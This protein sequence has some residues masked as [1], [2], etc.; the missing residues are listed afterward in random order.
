MNL[1][2]QLVAV[3]L[4]LATAFSSVAQENEAPAEKGKFFD[5]NKVY[6]GAN[7]GLSLLHGDLRQ[8]N[9]APV[10]NYHSE[11]GFGGNFQAGMDLNHAVSASLQF[12]FGSLNGTRRLEKTQNS[13][14]SDA[15]YT[16]T[17]LNVQFD[18]TKLLITKPNPKFTYYTSVGVG[19]MSFRS[20]AYRLESGFLESSYG[21]LGNEANPNE[22]GEK[23]SR[24]TE[25]VIPFA[26]G[27]KYKLSPQLFLNYELRLIYTNTDKLDAVV[28]QDNDNASLTSLGITYKF[29]M[30]KE[31]VEWVDPLADVIDKVE[32][33]ESKVE[34][35]TK[36]TDGDG[37]ADMHDKEP[38]T[39]AGVAVDGAGRALDVDGDGVP[40]YQDEEFS[41]K[42]AKVDASGRELDADGD[43]VADSKDQEPNTE[44]GAMVNHVGVTITAKAGSVSAGGG[45]SAGLPAVYFNLNSATVDYKSYG[46]LAEIAKYLQANKDVKLIVVGH[47][48]AS[49]SASYNEKLGLRRAQAVIDHLAKVYG[50]DA[51]RLT[52]KSKGKSEPL[53]KS[54]GAVSNINRRVD[55]MIAQ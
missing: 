47:T 31:A 21:Y 5:I 30:E 52:P 28:R 35:I 49:G 19:L 48:D 23:D 34:T 16:T 13:M 39:P 29:A 26:L 3:G 32:T 15:N 38:N 22:L 55:F 41:A 36:D 42:G 18:L 53:A 12:G 20:A 17:S 11:L 25:A 45:V 27:V 46:A 2:K 50:I 24:T 1:N 10:T 14:Y 40:D 37:V 43:G 6:V 33:I 9:I 4:S 51:S 7:F 54:K 44:K 8:Y